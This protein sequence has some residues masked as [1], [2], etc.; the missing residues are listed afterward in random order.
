MKLVRPFAVLTATFAAALGST[1]CFQVQY[2]LTLDSDLAG[3]VS[4]LMTIDMDRMAVTMA[5]A[6][7]AMTGQEG[8]PTEEEI[9]AARAELLRQ[10]EEGVLE[11][12]NITEELTGELP[13]GFELIDARQEQDG[14]RTSVA[15]D[16]AFD[17]VRRLG[18]MDDAPG[19]PGG[20]DILP[21]GGFEVVEE[22]NTLVI[23]DTEP[24]NPMDEVEE[25]AGGFLDDD[26]MIR[27][28]F[29]DLRI[30]FTLTAPF[31]VIEHNATSQDGSKLSWVYDYETLT[32]G[33]PEG[34]YVRYRK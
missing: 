29:S 33:A 13:E 24:F 32:A 30:A 23:R 11:K 1:G 10:M 17:H 21:F 8:P 6:Q 4:M 20:D 31:E 18:E 26:E 9:E 14:L 15:I 7:R 34:I 5:T 19:E 25:N 12:E 2:D 28:M 27:E 16:L 22:G 3:T